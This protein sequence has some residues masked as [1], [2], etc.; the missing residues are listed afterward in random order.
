MRDQVLDPLMI[1]LVLLKIAYVG[2][3]CIHGKLNVGAIKNIMARV[4]RYIV[5]RL[6]PRTRRHLRSYIL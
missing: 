2:R 1:F 5:S 4:T 3:S 6:Y